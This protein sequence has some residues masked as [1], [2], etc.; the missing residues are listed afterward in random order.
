MASEARQLARTAVASVLVGSSLR[1]SRALAS[2]SVKSSTRNFCS[3]TLAASAPG[4]GGAGVGSG[5]AVAIS[6]G[7][8][9]GLDVATA[10][11]VGAAVGGAV[12]AVVDA[13]FGA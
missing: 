6:V 7:D 1:A 9:V 12:G 11:R 8:C 2:A 5:A 10:T 4:G 3:A 13:T